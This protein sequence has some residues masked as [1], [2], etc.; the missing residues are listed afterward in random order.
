MI[1]CVRAGASCQVESDLRRRQ[2]TSDSDQAD[3]AAD[4]CRQLSLLASGATNLIV[5]TL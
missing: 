3:T 4:V 2:L 1:C 5:T